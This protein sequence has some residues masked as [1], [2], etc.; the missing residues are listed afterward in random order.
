MFA[1]VHAS[2]RQPGNAE[3]GKC[4]RDADFVQGVQPRFTLILNLSIR[5]DGKRVF[6][7]S[8]MYQP[9]AF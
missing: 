5:G 7:G 8:P 1:T 4:D 2:E 3:Q 9:D 6:W